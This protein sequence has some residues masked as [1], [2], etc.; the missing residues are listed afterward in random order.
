MSRLQNQMLMGYFPTPPSLIDAI[1]A[2]LQAHAGHAFCWLDPGGGEGVALAML[3]ARLGGETYDIELDAARAQQAE[4]RLQHVLLGDF[5]DM[6]LP[7]N[8]PG[9]SVLF[10]NPPYDADDGAGRRLELHF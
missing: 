4:T 6:R 10:L 9:V 3:Q 8:P 2:Q 1:E 7:L 5:A